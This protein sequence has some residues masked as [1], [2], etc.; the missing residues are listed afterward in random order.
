LK[1]FTDHTGSRVDYVFNNAG[2]L[3]GVT[4]SGAHS[5]PTYLANISYRAWGAIKELDFGN[6]MH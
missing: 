2:M 1:A 5:M 6:G 3:T 4:G